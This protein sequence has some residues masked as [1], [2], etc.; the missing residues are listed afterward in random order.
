[1]VAFAGSL[2]PRDAIA[3]LV[4]ILLLMFRPRGLLGRA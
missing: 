3:F 1:M 2:M 4:L